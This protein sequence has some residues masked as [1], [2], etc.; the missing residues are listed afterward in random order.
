MNQAIKLKTGDVTRAMRRVWPFITD[1]MVREAAD[2]GQIE[3]QPLNPLAEKSHRVYNAD[4]LKRWIETCPALPIES[5]RL[6]LTEL[7]LD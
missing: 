2:T 5:R 4:S 6:I 3:T 1:E 7:G